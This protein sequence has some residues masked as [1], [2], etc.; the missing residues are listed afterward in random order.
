MRRFLGILLI[1][2]GM[3]LI[4]GFSTT[5]DLADDSIIVFAQDVDV[6][7]DAIVVDSVVSISTISSEVSTG[8]TY[9]DYSKQ[10]LGEI[11]TNTLV[12]RY[13]ESPITRI[14][15]KDRIPNYTLKNSIT[16]KNNTAT[17]HRRARDGIRC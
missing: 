16:I 6:G 2:F 13:F 15:I 17:L 14:N 3:L 8:A 1:S 11:N 7:V 5:T 4:G 12:T 10:S 9:K